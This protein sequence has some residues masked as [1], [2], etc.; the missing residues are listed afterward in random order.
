MYL[1][2]IAAFPSA[3][4]SAFI[5]ANSFKTTLPTVNPFITVGIGTAMVH[6]AGCHRLGRRGCESL[7]GYWRA[8]VPCA[9]P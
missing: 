4:F 6:R 7:H 1:L 2:A 8:S 9:A 5:A 3:C